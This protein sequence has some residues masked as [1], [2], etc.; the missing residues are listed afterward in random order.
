MISRRRFLKTGGALGLVSLG[1]ACRPD[2]QVDPAAVPTAAATRESGGVLVNDIHSQLNPTEVRRIVNVNS[3]EELRSAVAGAAAEATPV[4]L[5]GGRHAM[6][7]QQFGTDMVLIDTAPMNHVV[8]FDADKGLIEVEAGIRWPELVEY[9]LQ[10][11]A[12]RHPAWGIIQKQTGAD[13]L[14]V[15]GALSANA[16]GR[17]LTYKPIIENVE[18]FVLIDSNGQAIRCSRS[19]NHKLFCL[20]FGPG[21]FPNA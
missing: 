15:G 12:G 11:Q 9:L 20:G 10:V 7:G 16:H 21:S 3:A 5:A 18:S 14:S 19:E 8:A 4:S 13:R 1:G 6:G 2:G 17:G